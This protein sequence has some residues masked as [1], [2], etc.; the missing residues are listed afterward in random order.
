MGYL[1]ELWGGYA[2]PVGSFRCVSG[3]SWE[4]SPSVTRHRVWGWGV[5]PF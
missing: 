3:E 4:T 2:A 1:G 5:S